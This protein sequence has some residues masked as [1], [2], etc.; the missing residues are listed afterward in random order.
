MARPSGEKRYFFWL[1]LL[2]VTMAVALAA[3]LFFDLTQRKS[4]KQTMEQSY[5]SMTALVF[6]FERE[7]LRFSRSLDIAVQ[8]ASPENL[9]ELSLRY[10]ILKL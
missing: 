8:N 10:D 2:T 3:S 7:F 1:S 6:Q 5:D 9:D 4:I